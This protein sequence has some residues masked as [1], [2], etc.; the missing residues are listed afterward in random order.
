MQPQIVILGTPNGVREAGAAS[1]RLA[2]RFAI[3][4]IVLEA[5]ATYEPEIRS[6][7]RS[8]LPES[9]LRILART[10]PHDGRTGSWLSPVL[11][12]AKNNDVKIALVGPGSSDPNER[13]RRIA[14]EL[15][16]IRLQPLLFICGE[17]HATSTPVTLPMLARFAFAVINRDVRA[18]TARIL[19][20]AYRLGSDCIAYRLIAR[21]GGHQYNFFTRRVPAQRALR[22]PVIVVAKFH[23]AT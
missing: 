21:H 22:Q 9:R 12:Y 14:R 18:A 5:A 7:L 11:R 16:K 20:A 23:P 13:E 19:P 4:T 2:R 10:H 3:R 8:Q 1:V 15:R 17:L 6:F